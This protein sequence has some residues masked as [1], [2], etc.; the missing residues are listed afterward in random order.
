M[1][2]IRLSTTAFLALLGLSAAHPWGSRNTQEAADP[3]ELVLTETSLREATEVP[4]VVIYVDEEGNPLETATETVKIV[5]VMTLATSRTRAPSAPPASTS[6]AASL[7]GIAYAPYTA[8]GQC[9]ASAEVEQDFFALKEEYSI[10]RTY[11]TDCD[12]IASRDQV[13][14]DWAPVDT[15]SV[16]NEL[17]NNGQATA[18]QVIAAVGL[19]RE[20]L[21]AAGYP[22]PVV[23]V[24]TFVA[25]LAN[26]SLCEVSDYCAVNIHPFFDG[27]TAAKDAGAFVTRTVRQVQAKLTDRN[28]RV[29]CTETGWPWKGDSNKMAVPS[30]EE[31]RLAIGSIKNA[32]AS[33]PNDVI[34]FSA[35]ND[36]WKH[37]EATTFHAEQY[38]GIGGLDLDSEKINKKQG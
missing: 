22:G 12:Q 2:P 10:V 3:N 36:L 26:P 7:Y 17:V 31:Q 11:G 29:V 25:V 30:L 23:T 19:T 13:N 15:I 20:L 6:T 5:P 24:D 34:L 28:K 4:R 1:K 38:W 9:K 14:G 35:F 16:G 18:Q 27:N 33:H 8:A 37:S 32:Y 21:R